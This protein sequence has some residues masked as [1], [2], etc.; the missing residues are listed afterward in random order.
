[1]S[2]VENP[3]NHDAPRLMRINKT[4][5]VMHYTHVSEISSVHLIRAHVHSICKDVWIRRLFCTVYDL[6]ELICS[7]VSIIE[8]QL[9]TVM[10][11]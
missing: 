5:I 11:V 4:D 9:R 3:S 1:M 8:G 7:L 2:T 10:E 6:T